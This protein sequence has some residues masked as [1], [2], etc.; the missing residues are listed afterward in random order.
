LVTHD[1][2]FGIL[3]KVEDKNIPWAI[4]SYGKRAKDGN[5][6]SSSFLGVSSRFEILL[7]VFSH[8]HESKGVLKIGKTTYVNIG[9]LEED[10]DV[11]EITPEGIKVNI[12]FLKL[13]ARA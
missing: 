12:N 10:E 11:C 13:G 1:P 4:A 3:D 9:S 5:I 6:G 7:H 2:P 8:V